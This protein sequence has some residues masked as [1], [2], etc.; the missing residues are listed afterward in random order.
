MGYSASSALQVE[1]VE[2]GSAYESRERMGLLLE[3]HEGEDDVGMTISYSNFGDVLL[4]TRV[5]LTDDA[6]LPP[7]VFQTMGVEIQYL[8]NQTRE[9]WENDRHRG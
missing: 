5:T 2:A 7:V 8:E 1:E 9:Q 4:H 6:V 3:D